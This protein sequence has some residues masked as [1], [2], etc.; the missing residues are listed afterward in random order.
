MNLNFLLNFLSRRRSVLPGFIIFLTLLLLFLTL[1]PFHAQLPD[2]IWDYDKAG[3]L[4]MFGAWTFMLGLQRYLSVN[5]HPRYL[6]LFL[7][8]TGFGIAIEIM[9]YLLPFDREPELWDVVFDAF[10]CI[11]AIAL[12]KII[13]T[14]HIESRNT[15]E[16]GVI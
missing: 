3:H 9:Q 5:R 4:L 14:R 6:L 15:R 16:P 13:L 12:L 8:G 10:G 2:S 11:L 1:Y 7:A